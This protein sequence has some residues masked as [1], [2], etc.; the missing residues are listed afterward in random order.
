[1]FYCRTVL[2]MHCWTQDYFNSFHCSIEFTVETE[3]DG[4]LPLLYI[5]IYWRPDWSLDHTVFRK[6]TMPTA[7]WMLCHTTIQSTS[8]LCFLLHTRSQ[9]H[10]QPGE[11]PCWIG[12]TP[13]N[14]FKWPSCPLWKSSTTVLAGCY[15]LVA[16]KW[17][18]ISCLWHW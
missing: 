5:D 14:L 11:P 12:Y 9:S 3:K 7:V 18:S 16:L 17:S 1:M 10:V 4:H 6:V 2:G 13:V 15:L 8:S